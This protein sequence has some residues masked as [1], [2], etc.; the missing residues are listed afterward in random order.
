MGLILKTKRRA[1]R[2]VRRVGEVLAGYEG[3]KRGRRLDGW[4]TVSQGSAN[5]E[6][7]GSL[8]MLRARSRDLCRNTWVGRRAINLIANNIVGSSIRPDAKNRDLEQQVLKWAKRNHCDADEINSLYGMQAQIVRTVVES[9]EALVLR[10]W[11]TSSEG[12]PIPIQLRVIEPDY[13]DHT[14]Y[15]KLKNGNQIVQGVEFDRRGR[16]VAYWLFE[17]HPG[18]I[19]VRGGYP[20]RRR[21]SAKDCVHVFDPVRAGQV[22]GVP[23]LAPVILIIRGLDEYS[24]AQITRQKIAACYSAFVRKNPENMWAPT[25]DATQ[26]DRPVGERVEPGMI[27]I[28]EPGEDVT[29]GQ[30]P[31][32][33]GYHEFTSVTLHGVAAGLGL[34]YESLTGDYSGVNYSSAQMGHEEMTTQIKVW[35][36]HIFLVQL[37]YPVSDWLLDAAII[38][39]IAKPE[40]EIEWTFPVRAPVDPIKAEKAS[41]LRLR[42][43]KSSLEDEI[44]M[45]GRDFED[46]L[47]RIQRS[48]AELDRRGIILDSDPRHQNFNGTPRTD[49][50]NAAGAHSPLDPHAHWLDEFLF[51]DDEDD[52][53]EKD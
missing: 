8:D 13:L 53:E 50:N 48:N 1:V 25:D 4:T 20:K 7:Q 46:V 29:F 27:E 34:S 26:N 24:D 15:E 9:G 30:P 2:A 39:G 14:F 37:L 36:S 5:T 31:T 3:A 44:R 38:M 10:E 43:G 33:E 23:W 35:Q 22:R 28:L 21:I 42:A 51:E 40:D 18:D 19:Y 6:I 32:I 52:D 49:G 11:R 41:I 12:L 17:S 16:R 45:A 47:D